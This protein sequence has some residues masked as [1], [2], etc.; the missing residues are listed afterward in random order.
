MRVIVMSHAVTGGTTPVMH[1]NV[2]DP[3][4]Y[5]NV[6]NPEC[7]RATVRPLDTNFSSTV[8]RLEFGSAFSNLTLYSA[9]L[10]HYQYHCAE[11]DDS[12][13]LNTTF[14]QA[15]AKKR[16]LLP[17]ANFLHDPHTRFARMMGNPRNDYLEGVFLEM[18]MKLNSPF[19]Y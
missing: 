12:L 14:F 7:I 1:F 8:L 2:V 16:G 15:V 6:S 3:V 11:F 5:L 19:S 17:S 13:Y 4:Y 9:D 18:S 10:I